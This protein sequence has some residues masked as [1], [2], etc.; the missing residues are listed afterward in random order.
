MNA[1]PPEIYLARHGETAWTISRHAMQRLIAM[2]DRFDVAWACDTDHDRHGIVC[3]SSGLL[4]PNHFLA[5]A[6]S[7]LFSH[8]PHWPEDAGVGKTVVSSSL[9]D[10]V[11]AKLGRRLFEVPVGFKWFVNGFLDGSLA[12]GGEESAGASFLRRDGTV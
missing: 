12:F 3:R 11:V 2:K 7:Y 1:S 8:L 10:R 9:I 5:V 4:N 6:I